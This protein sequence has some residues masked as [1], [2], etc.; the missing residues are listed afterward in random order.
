MSNTHA[1]PAVVLK[2][3]REAPVL[4]R[5]PWIFSG[6]IQQISAD[7][8]DGD[9]I[10]LFNA[11]GDWL[12]RGYLNRRSQIQVRLLSWDRSEQIDASFWRQRIEQ[13]Y[14][15]RRSIHSVHTNAYRLINGESDYLPGLIV[16]R[17]GDVLVMQSGTLGIDRQRDLLA[18]LLLEVTGA[19]A[20]LERSDGAL[21]REEGLAEKTGL[22]AGTLAQS[23]LEITEHGQRFWVDLLTGQKS[24]FYTDQRENRRSVATYCAGKTVLNVFSYTGA[25]A[26]HALT[27]GASHVINVDTS[28]EALD[29]A[30]RNI[31][32][33]HPHRPDSFENIAANAFEL[34]RTWRD[35][36]DSARR[37]DVV[38]LDPPKFAQSKRNVERALRGYKDINLLAMKLLNPNGILATFSCSGLIEPSLFQRAVFAAAVDAGRNA[39]ILEWRHAG[40]DHPVALTFPEGNYL[41]G[42]ICRVL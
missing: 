17:Y 42:L 2:R 35:L 32:L 9:I 16:D 41:K 5:H 11:G 14:D 6:A 40:P 33:N 26:V 39:Q 24:G 8:V 29:L 23:T 18:R 15:R 19:T 21:R 7:A 20:V 1:Y 22:L 3:K 31:T 36:G 37:F 12:A 28:K 27:A 4:N 25:F 38:I 10:D 13:A 34:L 30:T